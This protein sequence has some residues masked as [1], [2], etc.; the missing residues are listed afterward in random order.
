[1]SKRQRNSLA[2][3][4]AELAF[5]VPPVMAHRIARMALAGAAP[6]ERD[7]REFTRMSA[8][9]TTAFQQSWL[10]MGM[11]AWRA[12]QA[13]GMFW[14]RACLSPWGPPSAQAI[15]TQLQ[16]AALGVLGHGLAPVHRTAV[17]NAKRL[18]RTRLR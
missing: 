9:K 6:S 8:E 4:S 15:G 16:S 3:R 14:W 5:A 7:R 11:Q 10:A 13:F 2:Q 18:S 1:M 12:Q 17:A